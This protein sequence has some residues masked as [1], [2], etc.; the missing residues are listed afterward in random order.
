M[1]TPFIYA[2]GTGGF[3]TSP[4]SLLTTELDSLGAG[5]TA[6]STVNGTSGVFSQSDTGSAIW[7]VVSFLAGGSFTPT[8]PNFLA[9]WFVLKVDGTNFELTAANASQP[10]APD[11]T[12]PLIA[13]AYSTNNVSAAQ[14]LVRL[15]AIPFQVI[16]WNAGGAAL[17]SSG[18]KIICGPVEVQY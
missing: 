14:S 4:F 8:T 10:R 2:A 15:P 17:P 5:D 13:A 9:G 7:S 1:A 3:T 6:L 12:I 16:L 11:F 18:N